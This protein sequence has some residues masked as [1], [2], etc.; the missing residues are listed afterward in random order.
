MNYYPPPWWGYGPGPQPQN[1]SN[2]KDK[3]LTQR[4]IDRAVRMAIGHRE[5]SKN[6][7][8]KRREE[9]GKKA[10]AARARFFSSLEWFIIGILMYPIVGPL[11]H[12]IVNHV[13]AWAK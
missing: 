7:K 8:R 10:A 4:D 12:V 13:E 11:Y 6:Q 3:K 9:E 2:K 5:H 1:G